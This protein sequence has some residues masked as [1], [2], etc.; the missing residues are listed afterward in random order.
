MADELKGLLEKIQEDGVRAAEE[1]ARVIEDEALRS[2]QRVS[3]NAKR[4][5]SRMIFEAEAKIVRAEDS[6]KAALKQAS[7]DA[8]ISL[9]K[10]ISDTLER[11]ISSHVHKALASDE[12]AKILA[13]LI[14]SAT[15][16]S[17]KIAITLK[18]EDLDKAEKALL[19]ELKHEIRKGI[20]LKSSDEIHG[21]FLI[22]YDAGKSHY[23]F[24][25][26][27]LAEYISAN[28]AGR[29]KEILKESF[30]PGPKT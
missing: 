25:D 3:D 21:G 1:K 15:C 14:K 6:S 19:G 18:K 5:A 26:K 16:D 29:L 10:E 13:G 11:I 28:L 4:E 30:S 9:K 23:D 2:A 8:I 17:D 22:S 27:A 7:R 24:T 12:M 20:T